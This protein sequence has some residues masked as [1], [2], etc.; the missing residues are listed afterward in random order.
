MLTNPTQ[1]LLGSDSFPFNPEQMQT[2]VIT[3]LIEALL[4]RNGNIG[5]TS[6]LEASRNNQS[7]VFALGMHEDIS[8]RDNVQSTVRNDIRKEG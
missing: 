8:G 1:V 3:S 5:T 7:R 2:L 4:A 6:I